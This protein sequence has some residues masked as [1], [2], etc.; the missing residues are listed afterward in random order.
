MRWRLFVLGVSAIFASGC[1]GREHCGPDDSPTVGLVASSA[2]IALTYGDLT[3][4]QNQDCPDPHA[5]Q[6]VISLT[7]NGTQVD[8]MGFIT[9]CASRPDQLGE[10]VPIGSAFEIVDFNGEANSCTF[11]LANGAA[12]T[13]TARSSGLCDNGA[14]PD[15]YALTLTGS[16]VLQRL[17]SSSTDTVEFQLAGTVAVQPLGS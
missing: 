5:P 12:P 4:S 16:L 7:V 15:G 11:K 13:G 6:G 9:L 8:G 17:C 10:G 3:S 14:S 2:D 1:G